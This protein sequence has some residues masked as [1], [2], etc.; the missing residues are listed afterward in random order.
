MLESRDICL[1]GAGQLVG[2]G[3]SELIVTGTLGCT[4]VGDGAEGTKGRNLI[5]TYNLPEA[6]CII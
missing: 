4:E 3:A 2:V 1:F 5:H 6:A